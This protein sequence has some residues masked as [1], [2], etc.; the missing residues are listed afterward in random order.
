MKKLVLL[1]LLLVS[2]KSIKA[3]NTTAV[4]QHGTVDVSGACVGNRIFIN[5]TGGHVFF[6]VNHLW[7]LQGSGSVTS[8]TGTAPIVSSGGATPAISCVVATGSVAGCLA[9][10]DFTTF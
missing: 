7:V 6:C 9:S 5:D 4:I 1:M 2:L 10:A 8:V 3:Q